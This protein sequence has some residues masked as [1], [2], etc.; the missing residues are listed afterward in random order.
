MN[1]QTLESLSPSKFY[2]MDSFAF[3]DY[4]FK[5]SL[6][7]CWPTGVGK[8]HTAKKLLAKFLKGKDNPIATYET[9][10]AKFKQMVKSNMLV[11]RRPQDWQSSLESYPLEVMLRCWLLL[12]DDV[13]VSDVTEAYLRDFT[14][15][16]DERTKQWLPTIFTT[17]LTRAELKKKLDE[18]VVSRMLFNTDV[19]AFTGEDK[20]LETT[21]FYTA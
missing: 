3:K 20:R 4:D 2:I 8:T 11:L 15:I 18:R 16:I 13:G 6:L 21:K 12:Y 14:F 7:F 5:R 1:T 10:D 17:N 19:V 9:S